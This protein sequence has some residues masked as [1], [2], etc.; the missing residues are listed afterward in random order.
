MVQ[1]LEYDR[2]LKDALAA[3]AA[4]AGVP[5]VREH[6]LSY[7]S[8]ALAGLRAGH[9]SALLA[10]FDEF[11]LPAHYHQPTDVPDHVDFGAVY[12]AVRVVEATV[13]RLAT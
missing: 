8:D 7:G 12:D 4:D 9:A 11:K 6:W 10:S 1:R 13:R 3:G 5:V 2:G